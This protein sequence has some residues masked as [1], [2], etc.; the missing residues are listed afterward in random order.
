MALYNSFM[1]CFYTT[2]FIN[3]KK[4]KKHL[5][6]CKLL[7][8]GNVQKLKNFISTRKGYIYNFMKYINNFN[9]AYYYIP[10][11]KKFMSEFFKN[12]QKELDIIYVIELFTPI[13][14][15]HQ[16]NH[17]FCDYIYQCLHYRQYNNL[18]I[19]LQNYYINS[20]FLIFIN[21]I[22]IQPY[23]NVIH[24]DNV[25]IFYYLCRNL[26]YSLY[27]NRV[28][29]QY[30][31]SVPNNILLWYNTLHPFNL[32]DLRK[33]LELN[34]YNCTLFYSSIK[35]MIS[36]IKNTIIVSLLQTKPKYNKLLK[37]NVLFEPHVLR[38]ICEFL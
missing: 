18:R 11:I 13:D 7:L 20:V 19:L 10:Y 25:K 4:P 32:I 31:N 29:P 27:I 15:S 14:N 26:G 2:T 33:T 23:C 9:T 16:Y 37:E 21:I 17:Y 3:L 1:T 8:T 35:S 34:T 36:Q 38:M 22:N 5:K 24:F 12:P 28:F 6:F 30:S